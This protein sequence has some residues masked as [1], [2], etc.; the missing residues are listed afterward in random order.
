MD[1]KF[2][3]SVVIFDFDDTVWARDDR[4]EKQSIENLRFINDVLYDRAII[5][6][7]GSFSHIKEKFDRADVEILDSIPIVADANSSLY[8]CGDRFQTFSEC[9]I[10]EEAKILKEVLEKDYSINSYLVGD[11][12][13]KI[14]PIKSDGLRTNITYYLNNDLIPRL[15][16]DDKII[17]RKTGT[18]TIDVLS[19]YNSKKL[20]YNKLG[21][22][23]ETT[24]FIGDEVDSGNDKDIAEMCTSHICVKNIFDT[25]NLFKLWE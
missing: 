6:S 14:R 23:K 3:Y 7:G 16:L 17:A 25:A 22:D 5:V 9:I 10:K 1:K 2:K 24:L 13:L 11:V 8:I 19:V 4:N 21:L 15:G 20:V 18:S 12:N